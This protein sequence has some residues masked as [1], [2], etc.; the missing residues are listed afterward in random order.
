MKIIEL[1][2]TYNRSG[3]RRYFADGQWISQ[4]R[5]EQMSASSTRTDCFCTRQ[6][7]SITCHFKTVRLP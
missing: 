1:S 7:G 4:D 6:R 5:Y 3:G 2:T